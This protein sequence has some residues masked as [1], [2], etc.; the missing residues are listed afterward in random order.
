LSIID[1]KE[2]ISSNEPPVMAIRKKKDSSLNKALNLVKSKEA[3]AIIS[4]GSTGAI[5]A[6]ALFIIGRIKGID[7]PALAPVM[8]GKN[9][10]FMIIDV[11][12]NAECKPNNLLQFALMGKIYFEKIL[13]EDNPSIGLINIDSEEEKGNEL[14]KASY[15]LLKESNLNCIG[16]VEPREIPT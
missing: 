10:P 11:G 16:N 4:A 14:T 13:K 8:P 12:A 3:D 6:G 9:S 1:A 2:V 7:R 5:M 15:N